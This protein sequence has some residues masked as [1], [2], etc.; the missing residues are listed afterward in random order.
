[1]LMEARLVGN[2]LVAARI[3][4][5]WSM[6]GLIKEEDGEMTRIAQTSKTRVP[7]WVFT[8]RAVSTYRSSGDEAEETVLSGCSPLER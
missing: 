6:E 1:M 4:G 3:R 2:H 5:R 8:A 7:V